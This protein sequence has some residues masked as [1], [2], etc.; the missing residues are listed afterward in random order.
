V[1]SFL[2]PVRHPATVRDWDA[3]KAVMALTFRSIAGQD[4]PDWHCVIAADETAELRT[5]RAMRRE[6]SK[7]SVPLFLQ[8]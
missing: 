4:H 1:L 8:P 2:I 3:V 6:S 5:H 7:S